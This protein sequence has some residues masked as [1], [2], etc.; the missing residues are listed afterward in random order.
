[1]STHDEQAQQ[2]QANLTELAKLGVD[3]YPRLFERQHTISALVD[4]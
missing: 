2:R 1:M 4:A 3:V